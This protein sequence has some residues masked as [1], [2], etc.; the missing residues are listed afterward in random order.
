VTSTGRGQAEQ[1]P[2]WWE[3]WRIAVFVAVLGLAMVG[4]GLV[5]DLRQ[6]PSLLAQTGTVLVLFGL[7]YQIERWLEASIR[8]VADNAEIL[9]QRVDTI[10]E[11]LEEARQ[12]LVA[13]KDAG[14][15]TRD[16]LAL[17]RERVEG[18]FDRFDAEPSPE[19]LRELFDMATD[20]NAVSN[21]GLRA[22][23]PNTGYWLRL[24]RPPIMGRRTC[25]FT[26]EDISGSAHKQV[27]WRTGTDAATLGVDVARGLTAVGAHPGEDH[28]DIGDLLARLV[29]DL[30]W[31]VKNR[32][33]QAV[34]SVLAPV[35]E[36]P[37]EQWAITEDGLDCRTQRYDLGWDHLEDVTQ[38][39]KKAWVDGD[40]L[41]D[42]QGLA[43]AL[44]SVELKRQE[45]DELPF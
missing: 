11:N 22:R 37:T 41:T 16:R 33:S 3:R 2:S 12:E 34:T 43:V 26:I 38:L 6:W 25:V 10:D 28:F 15:V 42:A 30:Q 24:G 39:L 1:L 31:A 4:A 14:A 18:L 7:L 23:I 9:E 32:S 35:I 45:H 20:L 40:Q 44:R 13:L 5:A 27:S 21:G 17:E 19:L 29:A 8:Q 36:L